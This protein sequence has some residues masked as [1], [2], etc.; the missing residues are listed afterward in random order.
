MSR[1]WL[2]LLTISALIL[3]LS[4]VGIGA[5]ATP[6]TGRVFVPD[7]VLVKFGPDVNPAVFARSI[8]ARVHGRIPA[9]DV[10][11]LKVPSGRVEAIVRSLS[12][13]PL[14]EYIEPNGIA[15]VVGFPNDSMVV[16][17]WAW[18]IVQADQA[19]N[20]TTG[21]TSVRVAVVDT[22]VDSTADDINRH[23]DL[24]VLVAQKDFVN[25][26]SIANDDHGHGTHVAG[27]IGA[28]TDNGQGVAGANWNV[29]LVAAKVCDAGGSCSYSAIAN[30]IT[31]A[32]DTGLAKVINISLGGYMGSRTLQR[33]VNRAWNK[34]A[35]LACAAGN[36]GIWFRLYPAAYSNCIAVAAT[37]ET[38]NIA[39][40]SNWDASWVD[41]AAP[42]VSIL[43]TMPNNPVTLN[44]YGYQQ[45]YDYLNGTSM[46]TPHVAGLAALVW[47][48]GSCTTATCVRGKIES[49]ADQI[50][51][52]GTYWRWGRINYL[53]AV[54]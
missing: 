39:W 8:G 13:H 12:N 49:N 40:F 23:P 28:L 19:W 31:W 48:R 7:E 1:R 47:A 46:A 9:L 15:R 26:D 25:N 41:V 36:D 44:S 2:V 43:S 10:Y 3:S 20:I 54:Q 32:V 51:G 17:Q 24:P 38:D 35:V 4:S 30:G 5:P 33:A 45:N 29:G 11:V 53:R 16:N 6:P 21:S 42:G 27:T 52:T 22:G 34:G 14:V 18:A 37:D 50:P